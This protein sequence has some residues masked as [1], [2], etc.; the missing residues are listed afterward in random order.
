MQLIL[1][2]GV[3]MIMCPCGMLVS[4]TLLLFEMLQTSPH[5]VSKKACCRDEDKRT[6]V[7]FSPLMLVGGKLLKIFCYIKGNM[8]SSMTVWKEHFIQEI[9]SRRQVH[10]TSV[11]IVSLP[12]MQCAPHVSLLPTIPRQP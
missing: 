3:E 4:R 5:S 2:A 8:T 9:T 11:C 6:C 7:I 12:F 10:V 1:L